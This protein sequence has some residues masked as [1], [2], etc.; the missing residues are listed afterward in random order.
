MIHHRIL[1]FLSEFFE[2]WRSPIFLLFNLCSIARPSEQQLCTDNACG[3]IGMNKSSEP[4]RVHRN[5]STCVVV[6]G[7]LWYFFSI[8]TFTNQFC[9]LIVQFA[10]MAELLQ[11]HEDKINYCIFSLFYVFL[12][13][14]W[15]KMINFHGL[16]LRVG[17][18]C[19]AYF[20]GSGEVTYI[21]FM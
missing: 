15:I 11:W 21:K 5:T 18:Y 3:G 2:N 8:V 14:W 6:D 9:Y 20:L 4:S 7:G 13:F 10:L 1:A 16:V 19:T 17:Q 12:P